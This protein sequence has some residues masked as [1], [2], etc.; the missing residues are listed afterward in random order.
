ME[1]RIYL[2]LL[3]MFISLCASAQHGA[4]RGRVQNDKG[5]PLS[6]VTVTAL[7]S[8]I[9][10]R[11]DD[12]G[13]Y[14]LTN[15]PEGKQNIQFTSVGYK[16]SS[17]SVNIVRRE[18]R[19]LNVSMSSQ[20]VQL[21]E[22]EVF[23]KRHGQ[24]K[25][26]ESITRM[27]LKPSDQIQ[28]ISVISDVVI[29]QQGALTITDAARNVPGVTLFG[30][31]GGVRESMSMRGFRGTPVLKNGVRIESQFQ[32][33]SGV[34]DMQGVE[35]IQVIKGS[36]AITQGV[37]TDIGNAGGVINVVTKTPQF[38][39]AA[40]VSLRLG[41]WGMVRPTFDVQSVLDKNNTLAVRLNGAFERS[42]NYRPI[43]RSNRVYINP[44]LEWRPDDKT[45]VTL[46]L[47]YLNDKRTPVNS[48]V[49]L[50]PITVD[51]L[52]EIPRGQFL[53]FKNEINDLS[54]ST[55]SASAKRKL[56]DKLYIRA[57]YVKANYDLDA[58]SSSATTVVNKTQNL[59][60]RTLSRSLRD[61]KN[62]VFQF[63]FVGENVKTGFINHTFQAGFD[64]RIADATTT[65]LGSVIIDTIDVFQTIPNTING[66]VAFKEQTPVLAYY[67][68][69]G[70]MAQD[71][72][73]FNRY[74]KAILGL[75]YSNILNRNLTGVSEPARY[76]WNPSVGLMLTP[77]RNVNV[78]GSYTSSTSLRSAGNL[79]NTGEEVG[80]STTEQFEVGIKSDWLDNRLR[81][82]FTYFDI[83]TKNLSNTEY[84][85]GTNQ[86]TGY[87]FKAGDLRRKG[88][89]TELN[90][91]VLENL[92]VMIGYAYLDA[93]YHH[94]PSYV[95]GSA[96]MNAPK[97]T[98]N[99][100]VNYAFKKA[101][102]GL[103]L[104]VGVYYVGKR[105]VN[106]YSLSPDGHGNMGGEK[107]FDMPAYTTL[108]AQLGYTYK[109]FTTR[110]LLNN[111]TDEVGFNS[112]YRGGYINQI[113]PRN[114]SVVFSYRF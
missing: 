94:S 36:A 13:E 39:D 70:A 91:R 37:I 80:P 89:E 43:V 45:T 85:P 77:L 1:M 95:D 68:T 114:F 110:L 96:P 88:I 38:R 57:A 14:V 90:G 26:L 59:R 103:T 106:E 112:Y 3:T 27:P 5:L 49:N 41:S 76:A 104:G 69:Y 99:G 7:P 98:A 16:P 67:T 83:A 22:V 101:L 44:S 63:D 81:F 66:S 18:T 65:S 46:E 62:T 32:T 93:Q 82:N 52:Y 53:G 20:D 6:N 64:Y 48:A 25:G 12:E 97:H 108:N 31:Y 86:T 105:P 61:D 10:T 40:E 9:S 78:F 33:A 51:S 58:I 100:W 23:G 84:I 74:V 87:V 92:Q 102:N 71:V 30:S 42:D 29:Q 73:T 28:S 47:D 75:R 35:S 17:F 60:R 107:P 15:L 50:G 34:T 111:I 2:V 79:L 56:S 54:L 11:T 4:V 113:D 109:K 55:F 21:E 24:P 72:I 19:R 8:N